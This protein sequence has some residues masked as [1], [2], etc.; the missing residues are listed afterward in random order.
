VEAAQ[1]YEFEN[2]KAQCDLIRLRAEA[3]IAMLVNSA[4]VEVHDEVQFAKDMSHHLRRCLSRFLD[5]NRER[6]L[7]K[8]DRLKPHYD[9]LQLYGT[10]LPDF[11]VNGVLNQDVPWDP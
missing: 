11:D 8:G 2:A 5:A 6:V 3:V 10:S 4:T 9:N 1:H 7:S